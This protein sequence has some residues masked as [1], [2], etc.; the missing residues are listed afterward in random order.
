MDETVLAIRSRILRLCGE[1]GIS[2][3]RL[4]NLSA[5]PPSSIK[6]ILYGKSN[7]PKLMT[8]KLIC[9]GLGIT[10]GEFFSCDEF[11]KCSGAQLMSKMAHNSC[12]SIFMHINRNSPE[13][14]SGL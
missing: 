1:R 11:D 2:V 14:F 3:N 6:N 4:A 5:V 10:L 13:K 9:D 12:Q 7:N 8:I